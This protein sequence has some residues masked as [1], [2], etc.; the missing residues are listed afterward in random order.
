MKKYFPI[1]YRFTSINVEEFHC[2]VCELAKHH[3]VSFPINNSKQSTPLSLI[4]YDVWDPSCVA[5][6]SGSCWFV[7]FLDDYT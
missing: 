1:T 6:I 4:Y 3:R 7:T 5:T 2:E